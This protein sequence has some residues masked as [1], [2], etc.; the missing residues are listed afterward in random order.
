M[1]Q[2]KVQ[3]TPRARTSINQIVAELRRRG[4]SPAYLTKVR[5]EIIATIRSL[6]TL[7]KM[8]QQMDELS[9]GQTEYRRA[10]V[11]NYKVVFTIQDDVLEVIVVQVYDQRRGQQ[12]I[13]ENVKP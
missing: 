3:L 1:R 13:E 9:D 4:V 8:H 10:L 7:P 11:L 5:R 6:G 12:W 2:Y